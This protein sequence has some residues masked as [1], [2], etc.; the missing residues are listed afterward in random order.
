MTSELTFDGI[1][2][3][4]ASQTL[5]EDKTWRISPEAWPLTARQVKEIE[6]VG[7]DASTEG[8]GFVAR[9]TWNVAASVGHWGHIHQRRNR[10]VADL[11]VAPVGGVWKVT[12][13]ELL[14]EEQL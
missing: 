2:Q 13:M 14:E 8:T 7:V 6:M 11:T 4:F 1:R 3:A 9:S 5:F 10:Y 12:G